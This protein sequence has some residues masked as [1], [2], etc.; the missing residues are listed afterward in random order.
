MVTTAMVF[1]LPLR[2]CRHSSFKAFLT[3]SK[4]ET[5]KAKSTE[6]P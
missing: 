3:S 1:A 6:L 4:R 5:L 2:S